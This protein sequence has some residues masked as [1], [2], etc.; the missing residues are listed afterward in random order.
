MLTSAQLSIDLAC[1][2]LIICQSTLVTELTCPWSRAVDALA[3]YIIVRMKLTPMAAIGR[4]LV[5]HFG[6]LLAVARIILPAPAL[7]VSLS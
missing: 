1:A 7:I 4:S 5:A 3:L 6:A 2:A